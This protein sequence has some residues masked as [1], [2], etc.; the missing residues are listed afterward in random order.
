MQ[1]QLSGYANDANN[2][3]NTQF[4]QAMGTNDKAYQSGQAGINAAYGSRGAYDSSYRGND[5]GTATNAYQQSNQ[6]LNDQKTSALAGIGSTIQGVQN[7]LKP[8]TYDLSQYNDVASLTNLHNQLGQHIASLQGTQQSLTP[9]GELVGKLNA[10]TGPKTNL[11]ATLKGQLDSLLTSNTPSEALMPMTT[12]FLTRAGITDPAKQ[13]PY[14]DYLQQ[15]QQ[16]QAPTPPAN[17]LA[18]QGA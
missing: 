6:G 16:Q 14:F 17:N 3:I 8:D 1:G 7:Q 2:R 18:L 9:Q 12:A 5:L 15:L 11:D 10:I 13:K 4:G